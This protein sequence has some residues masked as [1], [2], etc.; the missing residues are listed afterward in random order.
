MVGVEGVVGRLPLLDFFGLGGKK[1]SIARCFGFGEE[2]VGVEGV[3]GRLPLL[4]DFFGLRGKK[5]SISRC[6]GSGDG[7]RFVRLDAFRGV[8]WDNRRFG[9][10]TGFSVSEISSYEGWLSTC[11]DDAGEERR[12]YN[13][14]S[15]HYAV[16]HSKDWD[17]ALVHTEVSL[18]VG[19]FN[20]DVRLDLQSFLRSSDLQSR[21][22]SS[23][24]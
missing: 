5:S 9:N 16:Q 10:S 14:A 13:D 3:V 24:A 15:H 8:G 4:L 11:F 7:V 18:W 22:S 20:V 19:G 6:L 12:T 21:R 17:F 2:A 1:S 23:R